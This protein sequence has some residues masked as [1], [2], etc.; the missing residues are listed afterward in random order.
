M[1]IVT[2]A[3]GFIGSNIVAGLN[4]RGI[5]DILLVDDLAD[6][7][8]CLNLAD[9]DF[10]DYLEYDDLL[11]RVER[12]EPLIDHGEIEAVFHQGAC[13]D[14]TEWDGRYVMDRNFRYSKSL[15]RWCMK[16]GVAFLYAS[17]ASVYGMG[18]TFVEH[19]DAETPLNMYAFSKLAF[20]QYIRANAERATS[21]VVGLRYFN[22]YGPREAHKGRMASVAS[23]FSAQIAEHGECRLFAGSDGYGDGEQRRDFIHVDDVVAVNLWLLDNPGVSGIFNCGTGAAQ[24]FNDVAA[25]VLTWHGRG[26]KR[27]IDF[28]ESLVGHYQSYTQ[29]DIRLLREAGYPHPFLTVEQGVPRYLEWLAARESQ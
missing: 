16:R 18:P 4:K 12:D 8:K 28:P 22:V 5:T 1:I 19:R 17:S 2:G 14:T 11:G 23:H 26:S 27:Y 7:H 6:G 15:Y 3:A 10:S 9:L 21:Q 25:A 24:S 20:D 29:A 13:S